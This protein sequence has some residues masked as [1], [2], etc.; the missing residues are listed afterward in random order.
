MVFL[1][2]T[3]WSLTILSDILERRWVDLKGC[4]TCKGKGWLF[5]KAEVFTGKH[6]RFF[7]IEIPR[8][9]DGMEKTQ[10]GKCFGRGVR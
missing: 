2:N 10:C 3:T 5:V 9:T 6:D 7:G 4:K 8:M 1:K